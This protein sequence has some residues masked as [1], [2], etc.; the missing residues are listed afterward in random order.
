[1]S[2]PDSHW[3]ILAR[4]VAAS[5][6]ADA[7]SSE[8][9]VVGPARPSACSVSGPAT[10]SALRPWAFWKRLI[11][12]RVFGPITPSARMPSAFWIGLRRDLLRP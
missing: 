5:A 12:R 8:P 10:P 4:T 6:G 1:M 9:F 2:P 7:E 11:A 3:A